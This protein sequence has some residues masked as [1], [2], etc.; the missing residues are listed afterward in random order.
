MAIET[1]GMNASSPT[2][3][4][5]RWLLLV[6]GAWL[7]WSVA[8]VS[9]MAVH[10]AL[11]SLCPPEQVISGMCTA[12]WFRYAERITIC[13]GV[14][15]AAALILL[16]STL[17]APS[18]RAIVIVATLCVGSAAALVMGVLASAYAELATALVVGGLTTVWLLRRDWVRSA[19]R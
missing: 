7:A 14:G 15:L 19:E 18:H 4:W 13:A 6:P 9:G 5:V 10:S 2:V 16:T 8:L 12:T 3:R 17:I 1:Q 11:E